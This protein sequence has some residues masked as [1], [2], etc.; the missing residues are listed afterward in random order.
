MVRSDSARVAGTSAASHALVSDVT[1]RW[2]QRCCNSCSRGW[3]RA[4]RKFAYKLAYKPSHSIHT[5]RPRVMGLCYGVTL[6]L[7][8]RLVV[9]ICCIS[10][11]LN[12]DVLQNFGFEQMHVFP[13]LPAS[14][15]VCLYIQHIT[16]FKCTMGC[17]STQLSQTLS[18]FIW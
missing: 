10:S 9:N 7:I 3:G 13:L 11:I 8:V 6:L 18:Y 12:V 5:D 2:G 4:A 16:W 15:V 1:R 14:T 17:S